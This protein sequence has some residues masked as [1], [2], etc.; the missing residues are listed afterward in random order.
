MSA[1][2]GSTRGVRMTAQTASGWLLA[3]ALAG[4][5]LAV[6]G[7]HTVTLC[8][9]TVVLLAVVVVQ[10]REGGWALSARPAATVL[11]LTGVGL[12]AFTALQIVPMPLGW[13]RLIAPY[14]ASVW[15]R[16]L[17]PLHEPGPAWAPISLDPKATELQ[18]LR[19]IAYLLAFVGALGIA[20]RRDGAAFL[21]AAVVVT[22]LALAAAALLHPAFGAH[23]LFGLYT[24]TQ[25]MNGRH[26]APLLNPNNLAGYLDVAICIAFAAV[27][28]PEPRVP[29][30]IAGAVTILLVAVQVWIASRSGVATMVLGLL[31]ITVMARTAR[32]RQRGVSTAAVATA[33]ALGVGVVLLVAG[34]SDEASVEL[35]D[36]N[37]SKLRLFGE[38]MRVGLA[39]PLFGCG[40]GAFESV[41]PAFRSTPGHLTFSHPENFVAQW[42]V[43]WGAPVALAA[44]AAIA[45]ALR[46]RVLLPRSATAVGAWSGLVVLAVQNLADLGTEIPGLMLAAVVCAAIVTAGTPGREP[47]WR[48][49][50]WARQPARVALVGGLASATAL[51]L[52]LGTGG[53]AGADLHGDQMAMYVAA[54]Q[55]VP[56]D[57]MHAM[58]R[59]AMLRHPAEPYLPWVTS[60]RAVR[61]RDDNPMPWLGATLERASVYPG[62]HFILARLVARRSPSQARLEYRLT[63][64]QAPALVDSVLE[65]APLVAGGYFSA[66]ELVPPGKPGEVVLEG[67]AQRIA[68]RL[69]ATRTLL[70]AELAARN[71]VAPGPVSRGARDAVEDLEEGDAAP[72]CSGERRRGCVERALASAAR[73]VQLHPDRCEGFALRARAL[74]ANGSAAD[75]ISGLAQAADNATDRVP[76][77]KELAV[78]ARGAGDT[79]RADAALDKIVSAGCVDDQECAA[80]LAWVAQQDER[81]GNLRKAFVLYRRAS[82]RAPLED[83]FLERAADLASRMGLHAEAAADYER[84]ARKHPDD[85][86]WRQA[87]ETERAAAM[88]DSVK[89]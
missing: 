7:V 25:T 21:S 4:A 82:D 44:F 43:E 71:P 3:L 22:G 64:E 18:V 69:P 66:M 36:A 16:A 2:T 6:G 54:T 45:Y 73:L 83:S 47:R 15:S 38:A 75:G 14:N 26:L 9:V 77:L 78:I 86:R 17:A 76:C 87:V 72:W 20:R 31:V 37:I 65:E 40:R 48:V 8:V 23:E 62:A 60:L 10:V 19:G 32:A 79:L 24:P 70:D 52:V 81:Y 41:F 12:V 61:E 1:T 30:A 50:R 88:R 59:A 28:S 39:M 34:G 74:V 89:L 35:F 46:P 13:L 11:V 55:R 42:V 85:V 67:L 68:V 57:R 27:L 51:L 84:L 56:V 49:E 53:G 80:S 33:V 5:A 58:A 63:M 29:R